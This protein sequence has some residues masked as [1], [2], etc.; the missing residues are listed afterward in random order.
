MIDDRDTNRNTELS[1]R[2]T[3]IP[4][5]LA[6]PNPQ[7]KGLVGV[8]EDWQQSQPTGVIAKRPARLLADYFTALLVLSSTFSFRP[9][10]GKTYYLYFI[11]NDW[12]LSLIAPEEWNSSR[13]RE[14]FVGACELHDDATWSISPSENLGR[15]G[16]VADALADASRG[17]VQRLGSGNDL[18]ASLPVY[19][20]RLPYHQRLFAAALGRSILG[21]VR[22]GGQEGLDIEDWI[23]A[24]P[25]NSVRLLERFDDQSS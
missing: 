13:R 4:L 1:D 25:A 8:L 2:R 5:V 20:A 6:A 21:S 10:R 15:P 12:N 24:L 14:A 23:Q 19:E 22:V 17:F 18:E 11:G 7:G 9:A 16:P 3:P